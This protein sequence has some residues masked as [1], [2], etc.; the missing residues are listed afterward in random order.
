MRV[1]IL[2][3]C[4]MSWM[5]SAETVW[6]NDDWQVVD[7]EQQA[8]FYVKDPQTQDQHGWQTTIYYVGS[9]T[10]RFKG[11]FA[12]PGIFQNALGSYQFFHNNGKLSSD[13]NYNSNSEME[14]PI[15]FY[16][17]DGILTMEASFV[18][19]KQRGTQKNF[20]SNGQ[21]EE[22]YEQL[23]DKR[24]GKDSHYYQDGSL[25]AQ[26]SLVNGLPEG[27]QLEYY[28]G[29][30]LR[31]RSLYLAGKLTGERKRYHR[32]GELSYI[33][34]FGPKGQQ[35]K[36]YEYWDT[37]AKEAEYVYVDGQRQGPAKRWHKNGQL[38][39]EGSYLQNREHGESRHYDAQG[40]L[41]RVEH[42]QQGKKVGEQQTF[43]ANSSQLQHL[44]RFDNQ[45]R[46]VFEQKFAVG[47]SKTME[48]SARFVKDKQILDRQYFK[49]GKLSSRM[50]QDMTRV[51]TL[52]QKFD[53]SGVV[54]ERE[55]KLKGKR[56][57]LTL[58]SYQGIWD[59]EPYIETSYYK[60]G[61]LHG[62]YE[63]KL[64]SG[65]LLEQGEYANDK[66]VGTWTY[67]DARNRSTEAYDSQGR[68]H[69]EVKKIQVHDGQLLQL[70]HYRHGQLEGEYQTYNEKG[71]LQA[72]GNYSQDKRHGQWQYQEPYE[73]QVSL[74]QGEYHHGKKVGTWLAHSAAG[75]E[76]GREQYDAK[77]Q[78]QGSFYYF[79]EDGLLKK[80]ARYQDGKEH[81]DTVSYIMGKPYYIQMFKHGEFLGSR[82]V[83]DDE[84]S[85]GEGDCDNSTSSLLFGC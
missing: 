85:K 25:Q 41:T 52:F 51:W 34:T 36:A 33:D 71:E 4:L 55:E 37:G 60:E 42:Y 57:G 20:Y 49:E 53:A 79:T 3:C 43:Y 26:H 40:Q 19:G 54:I 5:A 46:L 8:S 58:Q 14:G 35:G 84:S 81:G 72:K 28:P 39:W 18:D 70:A 65:K 24:V 68:L 6:L 1:L 66:K 23:G 12:K 16:D 78:E 32:N 56:E 17:E 74:W 59:D 2:L 76:L 7:R 13:G 82:D 31:E 30:Q 15:R 62:A 77:G 73:T 80:V 38:S 11:S 61:K 10:P 64:V 67:L 48:F 69:G 9:D 29:G 44:E 47:G 21:L 22:V 50:Q 27:E 83:D 45:G 63:K 75:Y